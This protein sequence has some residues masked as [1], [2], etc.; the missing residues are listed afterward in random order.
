MGLRNLTRRHFF[1]QAS[2]GIGGL[3][4]RL[5]VGTDQAIHQFAPL[6]AAHGIDDAQFRQAAVQPRHV[7]GK[8]ERPAA[9]DGHDFVHAVAE[10]EAAV[11]DAD[12]GVGQSREFA[13]EVTGEIGKFGWIH[14][15]DCR[16]CSLP[17]STR[18]FLQRAIARQFA[19]VA[20]ERVGFLLIIRSF[21][22][23][24]GRKWS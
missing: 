23:F 24:Q 16:L 1:E 14:G 8:A 15:A 3:A 13:V 9:V 20:L 19:R 18:A 7:F 5:R 4:L 17:C 6:R 10:D 21:V 11:H 22:K 12:L 2:F